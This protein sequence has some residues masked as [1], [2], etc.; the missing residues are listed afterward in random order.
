MTRVTRGALS[1]TQKEGARGRRGDS[2]PRCT[3][4]NARPSTPVPGDASARLRSS[5]PAS[6]FSRGALFANDR[7]P[8]FVPVLFSF[9]MHAPKATR[10]PGLVE[11]RTAPSYGAAVFFSATAGASCGVEGEG[12][13]GEGKR[14]DDSKGWTRGGGG[15]RRFAWWHR[16]PGLT[17]RRR[18]VIAAA[19]HAGLDEVYARCSHGHG[20]RPVRGSP[21]TFS[22]SS[23]ACKASF[24]R[25]WDPRLLVGKGRPQRGH[26][27]RAPQSP[28]GVARWGTSPRVALSRL[29][30]VARHRRTACL[31]ACSRAS[32]RWARRAGR[33]SPQVDGG[34]FVEGGKVKRKRR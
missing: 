20:A 19:S 33:V 24:P 15:T 13:E 34:R 3:S 28:S 23:S 29:V 16:T 32:R 8:C 18:G 30:S 7:F 2:P 9:C 14:T 12:R 21:A 1:E 25:L 6:L 22:P 5:A 4:Q 31:G 10:W 11:E 26:G 27:G 17:R